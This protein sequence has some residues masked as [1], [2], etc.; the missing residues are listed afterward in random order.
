MLITRLANRWLKY[1][2][3]QFR[4]PSCIPPWDC[5]VALQEPGCQCSVEFKVASRL[6]G[7]TGHH[8]LPAFLQLTRD[9][10]GAELAEVDFAGETEAACQSINAWV[11][12]QTSGRIPEL[13][14][15]AALPSS[16]RLALTNAAYFK[17]NWTHE[18][19]AL[20]TKTRP[21]QTS[22]GAQ[23]SVQ[24]MYQET[25]LSY[26][27]S[28]DKQVLE[29]PYGQ[30]G[31]V[32]MVVILPR[33][34]DGLATL[35]RQL[36]A[37]TLNQWC[38]QLKPQTV[39]LY[40]PKIEV[41]CDFQL[42]AILESMGI[43]HAFDPLLADFSLINSEERLFLSAVIHK[44][45]LEVNEQ[46]TVTTAA[47]AAITT[48]KGFGEPRADLVVFRADHQFMLLIRDNKAKSILFMG[49]IANP[50]Q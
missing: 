13:L 8:F 18:F 34:V 22:V 3:F 11:K 38:D 33:A 39:Q 40:L 12:E 28:D 2:I 15:P 10:Y 31:H 1:C 44:A 37:E 24:M 42:K 27:A 19:A 4:Q 21:F 5:C 16:T 25:E 48:A 47:T 20:A 35:N 23:V 49:Q 6:W 32:S 29:L 17:A 45:A 46:G 7:Q 14:G 30:D 26:F 41:S 50:N 43:R 36:A 9:H